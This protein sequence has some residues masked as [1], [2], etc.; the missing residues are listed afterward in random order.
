MLSLENKLCYKLRL[1]FY[2]ELSAKL[3]KGKINVVMIALNF[4]RC[5]YLLFDRL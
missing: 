5:E 4:E 3:L 2:N 1:L